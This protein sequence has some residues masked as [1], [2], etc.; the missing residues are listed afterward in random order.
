MKSQETRN[1]SQLSRN[2]SG[3]C[4]GVVARPLKATL[5]PMVLALALMGTTFQ[6][7]AQQLT[8]LT[9]G[10]NW[11]AEAEHGGFYQAV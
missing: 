6:A 11:L 3:W 8:K 2:P 4:R 10:T 5:A 7:K 1:A 9:Y